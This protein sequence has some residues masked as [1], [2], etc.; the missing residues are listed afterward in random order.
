MNVT[1][2][3]NK[4]ILFLLISILLNNVFEWVCLVHIKISQCKI[5]KL[6]I[7]GP[8]KNKFVK[9]WNVKYKT[10]VSSVTNLKNYK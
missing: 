10:I 5:R 9:R 6:Q 8:E 4:L 3:K 1:T 7:I 2:Y